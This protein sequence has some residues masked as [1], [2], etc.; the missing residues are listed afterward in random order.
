ML[1]FVLDQSLDCIKI[2]G[3]AG[4]VNYV[5][6]HGRCA[7]EIEDFSAIEGKYWPELWPESARPIIERA[8]DQAQAGNGSVIEAA[9]PD[10]RG[11]ERWWRIS[12]SPLTDGS[13][14]LVGIM[15]ISRDVTDQVR[16]REAEQTLALEMRH[17]LRNAYTVASAIL[18]QSARG[19]PEA[20]GFA[21]LVSERLADVALSQT[22]LLDAGSKNWAIADLV[23][24]LIEAHGEGATRIRYAGDA[25]ATVDG[26][27]AMLI[28]LVVGELTNNSL[29]YGAL[30]EGR[31]VALTAAIEGKAIALHWREET[32]SSGGKTLQAR[33]GGSGYAMMERMARVQR[34]TFTHR[35]EDGELHAELLVR[36]AGQ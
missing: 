30:R 14:A 6:S 20:S 2:L 15:T 13:D 8:V 17:R 21:E 26:H 28:A 4:E 9:R 29:K 35:L 34:A 32:Q 36:Q 24:N 18:M 10:S 23:R 11:D 3:T 22:Q 31:R 5:N 27:A 19:H 16:L 33:D 12:V 1:R 25:Q 7:L